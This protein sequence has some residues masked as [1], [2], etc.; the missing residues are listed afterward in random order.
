MF[1]EI[2][3][4]YDADKNIFKI[5]LRYKF[6]FFYPK[7]IVRAERIRYREGIFYLGPYQHTGGP[8][9]K[10]FVIDE[11]KDIFADTGRTIVIVTDLEYEEGE[12]IIG[13]VSWAY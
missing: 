4:K 9:F 6:D 3:G 12:L 11:L 2:L 13:D 10:D 8:P 7:D 1:D 5:A